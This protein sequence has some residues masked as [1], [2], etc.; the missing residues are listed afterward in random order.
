MLS[1]KAWNFALFAP[2]VYTMDHLGDTLP[3][4]INVG[5]GGA[6]VDLQVHSHEQISQVKTT[7]EVHTQTPAEYQRLLHKETELND[8]DVVGFLN[9]HPGE[10]LQVVC[11][12]DVDE[13]DFMDF[14]LAGRS[15]L[16]TLLCTYLLEHGSDINATFT[17][18]DVPAPDLNGNMDVEYANAVLGRLVDATA[19]HYCALHGLNNACSF[20]L[21]TSSFTEVDSKTSISGEGSSSLTALHVGVLSRNSSVC[22]MI[23]GSDRF[24]EV[25]SDHCADGMYRA[26]STIADAVR[27]GLVDVCSLLI[28]H[29]LFNG[30]N[31]ITDC[32][33]TTLLMVAAARN[34]D[35]HAQICRMILQN[36]SFT[37][38]S[39]SCCRGR[40][41]SGNALEI[42]ATAGST[43]ACRLLLDH[44]MFSHDD[45]NAARGGRT[46]LH[47]AAAN[48]HEAVCRILLEDKRFVAINAAC[49]SGLLGNEGDDLKTALDCAEDNG[50]Q[51]ICS[52]IRQHPFY[53]EPGSSGQPSKGA[54]DFEARADPKDD[55][56]YAK[57]QL[58]CRYGAQLS[59]ACIDSYWLEKCIEQ[60]EWDSAEWRVDPGTGELR[61]YW[62]LSSTCDAKEVDAYWEEVCI[63]TWRWNLP[64][65]SCEPAPIDLQCSLSGGIHM[66][67]EE[68]LCTDLAHC[69]A[70]LDDGCHAAVTCLDCCTTELQKIRVLVSGHADGTLRVWEQ[71]PG[72]TWSIVATCGTAS[73][74]DSE[75]GHTGAISCAKLLVWG[76][77]LVSGDVDGHILLWNLDDPSEPRCSFSPSRTEEEKRFAWNGI[78]YT[79]EEFCDYYG[80]EAGTSCWDRACLQEE[81]P[82]HRTKVDCLIARSDERAIYSAGADRVAV[83]KCTGEQG[84]TLDPETSTD[85]HCSV[86]GEWPIRNVDDASHQCFP[87]SVWTMPVPVLKGCLAIQVANSNR[88]EKK[89]EP[90]TDLRGEVGACIL[91]GGVCYDGE[92]AFLRGGRSGIV[93]IFI[94]G[95]RLPLTSRLRVLAGHPCEVTAAAV[96]SIDRGLVASGA[97]DGTCIVQPTTGDHQPCLFAVGA[98]VKAITFCKWALFVLTE[99]D[100]QMWCGERFQKKISFADIGFHPVCAMAASSDESD[101]LSDIYLGSDDG[102]AHVLQVRLPTTDAKW[103]GWCA[104]ELPSR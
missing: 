55:C 19:L 37:E 1:S 94:D 74:S 89:E 96:C 18:T 42:A 43:E 85:K 62:E 65:E 11:N 35:G 50:L 17:R 38:L 49:S 77:F 9:L 66:K 56:L 98:S 36:E 54:T 28:A 2:V 14:C 86:Q 75:M 13:A 70:I 80:E 60:S 67:A 100:L 52:L 32:Y 82:A 88:K 102:K 33:D 63:P 34:T 40:E 44:P 101:R 68:E 103:G 58:Q 92:A 59:P 31:E 24:T 69:G 26:T 25:N 4:R 20:L 95:H 6:C 21:E 53:L 71:P 22:C 7:L 97:R 41:M 8:T 83:W 78:S 99:L 23:L 91:V 10:E 51:E 47:R 30:L 76:A 45:I 46:A 27:F 12:S 81:E 61:T 57:W 90:E 64:E 16:S 84:F 87:A 29:P 15:D 93:S 79:K 72:A 104:R 3:L 73:N 48:N 5:L 39:A